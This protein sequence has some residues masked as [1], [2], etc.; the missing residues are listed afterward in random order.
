MTRKKKVFF[1]SAGGVIGM[2]MMILLFRFILIS[3]ISSQIPVIQESKKLSEPVW[4]Q[5]AEALAE[6]K[7]SPSSDNLGKLG[8]VYHS[9]AN[10]EQAALCYKLA[11]QR[12]KK[13]WQWYYYLGYLSLELGESDAM[14]ENF[15]RVIDI[16]P[17]ISH[18]WYY[19]GKAYQNLRMNSE[20]ES[21]FDTITGIKEIHSALNSES[22]NDHFPLGT[23]A[24][25]QLSRIY[26]ESGRLD[27][28]EVTLNEMI[29]ANR[30]FGP[31]YRILSNIYSM[32]EDSLTSK[33][34]LLRAN[35][36][37]TY[38]E[39]VDTL[40]DKIT[41]LSRSELYLPKKIDD[42]QRDI[43]FE[44]TLRLVKNSLQYIPDNKYVISKAINIYLWAELYGEAISLVDSHI[45]H[46]QNDITEIYNKGM[47]FFLKGLHPQTIE[48]LSMIAD[49]RP[50]D[51]DLWEKLAISY[52]STGEK[53]KALEALNGLLENNANDP[54]V[55][56]GIANILFFSFNEVEMAARRLQE[57]KR[58][59][60]LNPKVQK[61]SA[62]FAA[63][64]RDVNRAIA[65]YESSF[66]GDPEDVTTIKFLG[67]LLTDHEMWDKSLSLYR[68]A[69]EY[70]PNDPYFLER[71]GTLL[72]GCPDTSLRNIEEGKVIIE[73]AFIHKF[74]PPDTQ[75][76]AGRALA[77]AYANLGEKQKALSTITET[78][79]IARRENF[80]QS[81]LSELEEMSIAIQAIG[82]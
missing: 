82:N 27:L 56:A 37:L 45:S 20:A 73:R 75:V 17:G 3:Q 57:L 72:L 70:H 31:A 5:I 39:P 22:R 11:I 6:A 8:M 62:G 13:D 41:M 63:K 10:Y 33:Y 36:L 58:S 43:Q 1:Y 52:W 16:D 49:Q 64:N 68:E 81:Y 19:L 4:E 12:N 74:S 25:F 67:N 79:N 30:T 76:Y 38:S 77:F 32:K 44:W 78:L 61:L 71:L 46:F 47:A 80:S 24:S 26:L 14:L 48:Y 51:V 50:K 21:S 40:V 42:A 66:R 9:S 29:G 23:Y 65:L 28:A 2:I 18:A 15:K 53:Q 54:E 35:D 69:L 55:L 60:P 7:K 34:Y 59:A